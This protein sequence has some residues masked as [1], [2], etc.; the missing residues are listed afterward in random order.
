MSVLTT[1]STTE[2]ANNEVKTVTTIDEL[3]IGDQLFRRKGIVMHVGI[4]IG[5][6]LI[7]HNTPN[8]GEHSVDF[9]TFANGKTVYARPTNMLPY[10]VVAKAQQLLASPA[11][12]QLFKR[13]CEHTASAVTKELPQSAQLQE[14]E[15]WALIGGAL[16][17]SVGKKTM[18][19][20]GAIGAI[21]G[22]LS[23]S[24]MFWLK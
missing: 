14:I 24:R 3:S 19:I 21:G 1:S 11:K 10:R 8:K 13:N 20:G 12:Y 9:D 4:Y 7:L 23:L 15:A 5:N 6:Q 17:K 18:Y 16:G 22:L 2:K